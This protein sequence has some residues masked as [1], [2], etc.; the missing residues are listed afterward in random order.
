MTGRILISAVMLFILFR[1]STL[2][3]NRR[4]SRQRRNVN[5]HKNLIKTIGQSFSN[6]SQTNCNVNNTNRAHC[7]LWDSVNKSLNGKNLKVSYLKTLNM[8]IS[9]CQRSLHSSETVLADN[10]VYPKCQWYGKRVVNGVC[11]LKIA[12]HLR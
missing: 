7:I 1:F 5:N 11:E 2:H 9:L 3:H 12:T 6:N 10:F 8:F 4:W